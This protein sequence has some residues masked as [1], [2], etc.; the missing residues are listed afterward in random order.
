MP[1]D[2]DLFEIVVQQ[3]AELAD[4][5]VAQRVDGRAG[6]GSGP[7]TGL[8]PP[9]VRVGRTRRE[10]ERHHHPPRRRGVDGLQA[11]APP[12]QQ[13]GI[14]Q[15]HRRNVGTDARRDLEERLRVQAALP[16]TLQSK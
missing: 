16:H 10:R 8:V 3:S 5:A 11:L 6:V 13:Y 14:A 7:L 1:R 9:P 2:H 12:A 15:Q 4:I